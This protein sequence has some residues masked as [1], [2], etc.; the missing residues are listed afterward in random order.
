VG[1][2]LGFFGG[3]RVTRLVSFL[4]CLVIVLCV[5]PTIA[6]FSNAYFIS[7]NINVRFYILCFN[8]GAP[9]QYGPRLRLRSIW[10][11]RDDNQANMEMPM[12]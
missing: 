11:S 8:M 12:Y 6:R 10:G 7:N 4:C 2:P 5:V 3:F 1:S 9:G